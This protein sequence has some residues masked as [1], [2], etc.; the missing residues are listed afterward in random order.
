MTSDDMDP[1]G[2]VCRMTDEASFVISRYT[3]TSHLL[4]HIGRVNMMGVAMI[5][6]CI[7]VHVC[8]DCWPWLMPAGEQ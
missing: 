4:T 3:R 2:N 6:A 8:Y 7:S 5:D 1:P